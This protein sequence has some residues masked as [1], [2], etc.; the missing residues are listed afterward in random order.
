MKPRHLILQLVLAAVLAFPYS[1]RADGE[2]VTSFISTASLNRADV[3]D[4][5]EDIIYDLAGAGAHTFWRNIPISYLSDQGQSLPVK[6]NLLSI[7]QDGSAITLTPQVSPSS[8]RLPLS[9]KTSGEN[10]FELHYT[11]SPV[12]V[13]GVTNDI[14]RV[15]FTDLS[16][17]LPVAMARLTLATPGLMLKDPACYT[18]SAGTTSANCEVAVSGN[19]TQ[20]VTDSPLGP[21]EA[22]SLTGT[23]PRG[24]FTAYLAPQV[25]V[26]SWLVVAAA[27]LIPVGALV[28]V[29][30][31]ALRRA[32][33]VNLSQS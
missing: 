22:L 14:L 2:Q 19:T 31:L 9:P 18:G 26:V 32:R 5:H 1:A 25:H 16:F 6:F 28:L 21:G 17:N 23:F 15:T 3:L 20:V 27:A 7:K 8:V 33:R 10:H 30:I 4:V 29:I 12:V 11:L 13:H 24:S